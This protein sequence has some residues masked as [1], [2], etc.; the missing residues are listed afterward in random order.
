MNKFL[1]TGKKNTGFYS[2]GT[3]MVHL[4]DTSLKEKDSF[5]ST[6]AMLDQ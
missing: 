1:Q 3:V 6:V 5:D 2:P 4:Q